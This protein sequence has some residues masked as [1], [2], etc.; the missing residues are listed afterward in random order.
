M[1]PWVV[2]VLLA[3]SHPGIG[4]LYRSGADSI[5]ECQSFG[6]PDGLFAGKENFNRK[7]L[8]LHCDRVRNV[9]IC[10]SHKRLDCIPQDVAKGG[11]HWWVV[12]YHS[13]PKPS[14]E[15]TMDSIIVTGAP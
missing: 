3:T 15:V 14:A 10:P 12:R 2:T 1:T 11:E 7:I 6:D 9:K 5:Q 8:M 13:L 4:E